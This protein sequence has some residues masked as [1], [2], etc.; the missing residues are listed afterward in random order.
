MAKNMGGETEAVDQFLESTLD[1]VD[2]AES[3]AMDAAEK[4]GFDEDDLH[5]IGMAVRECMVNAVVHGNRYNENKKVHFRVSADAKRLT[6]WIVDQGEGFEASE[7]P[8]PLAEENLLRHS[9]RGLFLIRAFMDDLRIQK[10]VPS[11]TEVILIKNRGG[12]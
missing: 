9:G 8:D 1:S 5:K 11:G 4:A 6:I 10:A 3:L 12:D 2:I 7:L